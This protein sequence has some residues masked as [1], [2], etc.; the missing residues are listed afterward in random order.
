M[1]QIHTHPLHIPFFRHSLYHLPRDDDH[2]L[3]QP[4]LVLRPPPTNKQTTFVQCEGGVL[5]AKPGAPRNVAERAVDD[6]V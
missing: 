4:L 1:C 6:N 2:E 3:F 5:N